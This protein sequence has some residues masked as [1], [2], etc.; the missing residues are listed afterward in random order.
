MFHEEWVDIKQVTAE[1]AESIA[2]WCEGKLV[3]EIDPDD[4]TIT[5]AGVNVPT[6]QGVKRASSGSYVTKNVYEEFDVVTE[7][8]YNS[9]D[10]TP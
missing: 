10:Q 9:F 6:V 5:H 8:E 2:E 7:H 1:S 3:H 4:E